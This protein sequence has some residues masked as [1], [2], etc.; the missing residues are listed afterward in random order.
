[1]S[2][3]NTTTASNTTSNNNT[4]NATFKSLQ[5]SFATDPSRE[6]LKKLGALLREV[7][8]KEKPV[9]GGPKAFKIPGFDLFFNKKQYR[10]NNPDK[11]NGT[12]DRYQAMLLSVIDY[13]R[14]QTDL[15]KYL[16][17]KDGFLT[18][19]TNLLDW[20]DDIEEVFLKS[21]NKVVPVWNNLIKT[22]ESAHI[23][24]FGMDFA[25]LLE[26]ASVTIYRFINVP[27][28]QLENQALEIF[29]TDN[30]VLSLYHVDPNKPDD[31]I[32]FWITDQDLAEDNFASKK[33]KLEFLSE[34][35]HYKFQLNPVHKMP[36]DTLKRN[37]MANDTDAFLLN[38]KVMAQSHN[39]KCYKGVYT[40]AGNDF[41][42]MSEMVLSNAVQGFMKNYESMVKN[43]VGVILFNGTVGNVQVETYW[44]VL[45][46]IDKLMSP[47]FYSLYQWNEISTEDFLI[48]S[49]KTA[50]ISSALLH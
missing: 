46:D 48:G 19:L 36:L 4:S 39:V 12:S 16:N 32:S 47:M 8:K 43:T 14:Q 38:T 22:Y 23:K 26:N 34:I 17:N 28:D 31:V 45:D 35:S 10:K 7:G 13:I 11:P 29:A 6:F 25:D 1:M 5:S 20:D 15:D 18:E 42:E 40:E 24:Y 21:F 41:N 37:F 49:R 33:N 30:N 44:Y 9:G 3:T 50:D 27:Y 2:T